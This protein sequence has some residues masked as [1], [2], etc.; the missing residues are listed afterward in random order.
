MGYVL[1]LV[2][3]LNST[4]SL[5]NLTTNWLTDRQ[6]NQPPNKRGPP[7]GVWCIHKGFITLNIRPIWQ[8]LISQRA[9]DPIITPLRRKNDV[10]MSFWRHN[11][12]IIAPCVRWDLV[13]SLLSSVLSIHSKKIE[14]H[15]FNALSVHFIGVQTT[16]SAVNDENFVKK[17]PFPCGF[18]FSFLGSFLLD[19][20]GPSQ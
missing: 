1:V 4:F 12:V 15:S 3:K 16:S 20:W 11:D 6:A 9:H 18:F 8:L 13:R 10:A 5:L 7:V 2:G 14:M 19:T 17:I